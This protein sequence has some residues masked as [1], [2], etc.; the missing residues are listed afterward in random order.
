MTL[1]SSEVAVPSLTTN[2]LLVQVGRFLSDP[3]AQDF[4]TRSHTRRS[5]SINGLLDFCSLVE[6]VVLHEK[7][8]TLT[9]SIHEEAA[10]YVSHPLLAT[11]VDAGILARNSIPLDISR[12][13]VDLEILL[14]AKKLSRPL[15]PGGAVAHEWSELLPEIFASSEEPARPVRPLFNHDEFIVAAYH[16][17]DQQL[18]HAATNPIEFLR[19]DKFENVI[20][21]TG[22]GARASH[23]LRSYLYY[24]A[25]VSSGN[26]LVPDYPRVRLISAINDH[27]RLVVASVITQ[28]QSLIRAE[29][30]ADI[31]QLLAVERPL[32]V[33]L[34]A[35]S[36]I[37]LSRASTIEELPARLL[38]LRD[39]YTPLRSSLS[40]FRQELSHATNIAEIADARRKV[41]LAFSSISQE[42]QSRSTTV[43]RL[44]GIA[45]VASHGLELVA[46][47]ASARPSMLSKPI[48]WLRQWWYRRPLIQS[49]DVLD[50][51]KQIR[52]YNQLAQKVFGLEIDAAD[53]RDFRTAQHALN[54]MFSHAADQPGAFDG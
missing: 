34:P 54:S 4:E 28:F 11:I 24:S 7:L 9:G 15:I 22:E 1:D 45:D 8:G 10:Q 43:D 48:D 30:S 38:E 23:M 35:F 47:P 19:G 42:L 41:A 13:R 27:L 12:A 18:L 51:L 26:T 32:G 16:P 6:A 44:I 53:V 50:E 21:G 31:D 49:F 29:L 36:A 3:S 37:L 20:A 46:N 39:E 17:L 40:H 33:P 25:A 14:G 5:L 2:T 52:R